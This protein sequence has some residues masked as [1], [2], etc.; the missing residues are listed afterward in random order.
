MTWKPATAPGRAT[1]TTAGSHSSTT[2]MASTQ[3]DPVTPGSAM[4]YPAP[5][6]E[7]VACPVHPWIQ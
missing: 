3:P 6:T 7:I 4:R 2:D 1:V 5:A